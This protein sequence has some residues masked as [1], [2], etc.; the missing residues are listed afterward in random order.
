MRCLS[1]LQAL[2][3]AE[4]IVWNH[5]GAS[6][7]IRWPAFPRVVNVLAPASTYFRG[8]LEAVRSVD[9]EARRV[10]ILHVT[11]GFGMDVARGA[12]EAAQALGFEVTAKGF[13]GGDAARAAVTLPEAEVL[14]V[15]GSFDDELE[16]ARALPAGAWRAVGFVGAGVDEVLDALG[17]GL[18]GLLGPAQWIATPALEPDEGPEAEWAALAHRRA[19]KETSSSGSRSSNVRR[20]STR[21]S[22]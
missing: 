6:A 12:T 11:T 7:S 20:I 2:A 3:A 1:D 18:E 5:G 17:D 16:C 9:P 21:R 10:A 14:L 19:R 22:S 15:A 4:R 8:A 13:G